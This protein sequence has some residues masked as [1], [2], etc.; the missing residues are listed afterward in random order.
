[1]HNEALRDES[2]NTVFVVGAGASCELGLPSGE[3]LLSSIREKLNFRLRHPGTPQFSGGVRTV[4]LSL[5]RQLY[6]NDVPEDVVDRVASRMSNALAYVR[7]ID[8]YV[9]SNAGDKVV[10]MLAKLAIAEAI[11]EAEATCALASVEHL[12]RS[13]LIAVELRNTWHGEAFTLLSEGLNLQAFRSKLRGILFVVFNYDR[14]FEIAWLLMLIVRYQLSGRAAFQV[15]RELRVFHPYGTVG[16]IDWDQ[17]PGRLVRAFG[18]RAP[19]QLQQ[20]A[21]SIRTYSE[22]SDDEHTAFPRL[23]A[24]VK[25][26]PKVVFLGCALHLQNIEVLCGP[27]PRK[28]PEISRRVYGT[29]FGMTGPDVDDVRGTL[30]TRFGMHP[31]ARDIFLEDTKCYGLFKTYGRALSR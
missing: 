31:G 9:Q 30:I 24:L 25:A 13:E 19:G 22:Q 14:T 15:V 11:R 2:V 10:Q 28:A 21:Q 7:S 23:R 26:A 6:G 1:L 17:E 18:S 5:R 3:A 29:V 8:S 4:M 12:E 27:T 16:A 20:A